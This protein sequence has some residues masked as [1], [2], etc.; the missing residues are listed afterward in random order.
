M[1][2][3]F[4]AF[5]QFFLIFALASSLALAQGARGVMVREGT[6]R[7]TPDE[8]SAQL[9]TVSRGFVVAVL[10]QSH[11]WVKVFAQTGPAR[12]ET[13]WLMNSGIIQ[14]ATPDGDKI[15]FGEAED[16]EAQA[17]QA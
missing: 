6:L 2:N 11:D 5:I 13:G 7:I 9:G 10:E 14:A 3:A 12:D 1:N 17:S 15:I 8:G 4:R 16:S